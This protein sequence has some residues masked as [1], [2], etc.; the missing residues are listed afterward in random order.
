MYII[1]FKF[2]RC[3]RNIQYKLTLLRRLERN[4]H[5]GTTQEL[6]HTR[7]QII[8]SSTEMVSVYMRSFEINATIDVISEVDVYALQQQCVLENCFNVIVSY[9][10]QFIYHVTLLA[11]TSFQRT[12]A[13]TRSIII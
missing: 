13:T 1:T 11:A 9:H 8:H 10:L 4:T 5:Y 12:S 3:F 7:Y 2:Q 6:C